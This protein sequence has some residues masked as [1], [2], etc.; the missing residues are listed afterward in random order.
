MRAQASASNNIRQADTKTRVLNA[1]ERLFSEHG[2]DAVSLREVMR[3]A[4][5][6]AAAIHYHFGSKEN[7]L[8]ELLARRLP[9][10]WARRLAMLEAC[11]E[12]PGR[13]PMLEQI[14]EAFLRPVLEWT[15]GDGAPYGRQMYAKISL[16]RG[17]LQK[18]IYVEDYSSADAR[19]VEA[20]QRVF[21]DMPR[22]VLYWRYSFVVSSL[23]YVTASVGRV[24]FLS[25]G[26]YDP[27]D[28]GRATAE[29]VTL[30][31]AG[32]RAP[33]EGSA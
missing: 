24:E 29:L 23:I 28:A 22:E 11:V 7:L 12:S 2:V 32:F 14:L 25:G 17:P 26:R 16:Q 3:A 8:L 9:H 15:S 30:L 27:A 5:A 19:F 13:P 1:A 33:F 20:L 18:R 21:P 4:N 31:A 6:N 10:V